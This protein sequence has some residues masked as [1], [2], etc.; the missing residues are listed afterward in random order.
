MRRFFYRL[1]LRWVAWN[2][3]LRQRLFAY[4][5]SQRKDRLVEADL[6]YLNLSG[7]NLSGGDLRNANLHRCDLTNVNLTD[8]D[9]GGADLSMALVSQEQ[10][11][12][13]ASLAGTTL[14]DGTIHI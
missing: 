10:L 1:Y 11:E 9:L 14:P 3:L 2:V 8:A 5:L 4:W 6:S 7:A 13:A 12:S